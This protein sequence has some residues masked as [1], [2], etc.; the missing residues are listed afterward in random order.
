MYSLSVNK[1]YVLVCYQKIWAKM[2]KKGFYFVSTKSFFFQHS[3]LRT[4]V[5]NS[6]FMLLLLFYGILKMIYFMKMLIKSHPQCVQYF[7]DSL[8]R[9]TINNIANLSMPISTISFTNRIII[10]LMY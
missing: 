9:S 7:S 1:R 4:V 10:I 6:G 8:C 2:M 5:H 3:G